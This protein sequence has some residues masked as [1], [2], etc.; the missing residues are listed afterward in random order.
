MLNDN[1]AFAIVDHDKNAESQHVLRIGTAD[2][3]NQENLGALLVPS[4]E[5]ENIIK[6]LQRLSTNITTNWRARAISPL[7]PQQTT[8]IPT[9]PQP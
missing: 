3:S 8:Q 7:L 1:I 4:P 5:I 9:A 6:G 2:P